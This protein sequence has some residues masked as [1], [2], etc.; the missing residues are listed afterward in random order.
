M[1]TSSP[2]APPTERVTLITGCTSGIGEAAAR[3]LAAQPGTLVLLGRSASK[4]AALQAAL[5]GGLA[6]G[7]FLNPGPAARQGPHAGGQF[8][9]RR[10]AV[11]RARM[12]RKKIIHPRTG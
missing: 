12:G 7:Q 11:R 4:L 9:E 6:G 3:A 1:T 10:H 5:R 2:T 8:F